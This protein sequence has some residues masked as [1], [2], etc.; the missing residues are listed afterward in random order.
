M[1]T[2]DRPRY[3]PNAVS[4]E[5]FVNTV[6]DMAREVWD[7]HNRWGFGSGHFEDTSP[8]EIISRRKAILAEEVRELAEAVDE[9]DTDGIVNEAAD[10]LFVAI[11]HI[12]ALGTQ[13]LDGV[14]YVTNKNARKTEQTH[15]IRQDTGKLL[16][17]E[18]KPHKWE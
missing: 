6:S 11:G 10:V 5:E 3:A 12:E 16:P 17:K 4:E 14:R 1:S 7:F 9:N 15:A 2:A 18:G 13:G 8:A